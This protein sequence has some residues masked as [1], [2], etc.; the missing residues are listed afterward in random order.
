MRS[1]I[2]AVLSALATLAMA[3][4]ASASDPS[5]V[6]ANHAPTVSDNSSDAN[7]LTAEQENAIPYH[8]CMNAV[9]WEDGRLRCRN[10]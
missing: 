7:G 10:Y 3:S 4:A 8:P 1:A 6:R 2:I 9:G 5:S